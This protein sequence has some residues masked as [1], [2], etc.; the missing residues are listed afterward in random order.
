MIPVDAACPELGCGLPGQREPKADTTIAATMGAQMADQAL[1][2][3]VQ[4]SVPSRH[5]PG[6]C[7]GI[8]R[9]PCSGGVVW[10]QRPSAGQ[11]GPCTAGV[12]EGCPCVRKLEVGVVAGPDLRQ[13]LLG[14]LDRRG[15]F[16]C[17]A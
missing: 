5:V 14:R 7:P 2:A 3:L 8:G 16:A 10:L 15:R 9:L 6:R 1:A 17:R 4:Y 11:V 12:L 13:P